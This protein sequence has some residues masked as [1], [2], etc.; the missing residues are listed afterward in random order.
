MLA[1]VEECRC[2]PEEVA[3]VVLASSHHEPRVVQEGVVLVAFHPLLVLWV[4]ALAGFACRFFLDGAY[5]YCFLGL[6]DG[7]G[8]VARGLCGRFVGL[9]F[10]RVHEEQLREVV[11]I[12]VLHV[13]ECFVEVRG[14]VVVN[15]VA[16]YEL[17]IAAVGGG[18]FAGTAC[19]ERHRRYGNDAQSDTD[20]SNHCLLPCGG[21]A[22]F[23][24]AA[25]AA[26]VFFV[27]EG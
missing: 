14:A 17:L 27:A 18:V 1:D 23:A 2:R 9:R 26:S 11:L 12:A 7:A 5:L 24:A 4:A 22:G 15:V 21:V 13:P 25:G 3:V 19:R 6:F 8:E 16:G 20:P 10:D